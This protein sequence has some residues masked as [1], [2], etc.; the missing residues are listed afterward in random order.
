[1]NDYATPMWQRKKARCLAK[2]NYECSACGD[3]ETVLH[4]HHTVYPKGKKVYEVSDE[5]LMC[6]CEPCHDL[7]TD[8]VN[9]LR[10][11]SLIYI[12]QC[13]EIGY[14][15]MSVFLFMLR[16]HIK[17]CAAQVNEELRKDI[18]G[19]ES[20]ASLFMSSFVEIAEQLSRGDR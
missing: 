9:E 19:L 8:A 4:A 20:D 2:A 6:L 16:S 11:E 17:V 13:I 1:M 12:N 7:V 10:K 15:V 18:T 3:S 5:S 14:D